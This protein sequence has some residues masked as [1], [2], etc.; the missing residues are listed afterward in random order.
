MKGGSKLYEKKS[1]LDQSWELQILPTKRGTNLW[2]N[3]PEVGHMSRPKLLHLNPPNLCSSNKIFSMVENI[4]Y[5]K[6]QV[7][8][9]EYS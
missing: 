6:S 5:N 1:I 9:K 3:S 2:T 7:S 8:I 4:P